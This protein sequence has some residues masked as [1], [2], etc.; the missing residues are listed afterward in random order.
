[1]ILVDVNLL[2]YAYNTE[3]PQ[4]AAARAWLEAT[5][6]RAQPFALSWFTILAF[7]CISTNPRAFPYPLTIE[8]ATEIIAEV[9][10]QP[11]TILLEAGPS[12]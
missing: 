9:L 7:L 6:N 11:T 10:A 3:A 1:M 5:I 8:E 2:L 12:Y 4:H